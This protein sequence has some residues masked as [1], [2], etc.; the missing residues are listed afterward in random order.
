MKNIILV[1]F[2][3]CVFSLSAQVAEDYAPNRQR[4]T[5]L[6]FFKPVEEHLFSGDGMPYFHDGTFYL[7]WLLDEGHHSGLGGLG[8]H[9][10]ALS[11]S[12]DLINWKHYPVAL[13]INNEDWEKSICTGSVI[14]EKDEIYAFYATRVKEG[15]RVHE[16]LSYAI[17]KDGGITFEK[18]QPNPFYIAPEEC[19]SRDFRDPK[20]FKDEQGK[21]H[22]FISGYLKEESL[23]GYGG[24]LVH[25]IS[26]DLKNWVETDSPLKGQRATPECSDYFKWND[27][28]YLVYSVNGSTQYLKSK[29]PYGPWEYPDSQA[30]SEYWAVVYKTAAFKDNRRIAV[31][32]TPCRKDN[33]NAGERIWGGNIAFRELVQQKD[34]SLGICF[35]REV[36]PEMHPIEVPKVEVLSKD[37]VSSDKGI[38]E[39]NAMGALSIISLPNLPQNYKISIELEPNGNYDELGFFVRTKEYKGSGYKIGINPSNNSVSLNE[40]SINAVKDLTESCTVE[41]LVWGEFIDLCINGKRCLLNRMPEYDK[42]QDFLIFLKNG[43]MNIKNIE[44]FEITEKI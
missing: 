21:F 31:A 37:N 15:E 30:L 29:E 9:Q 38:I 23:P 5:N 27:W 32:Y 24:Y 6:Q 2:L 12:T 8:G 43:K 14:A 18:Q 22:L 28:Y 4:T 19:V 36:L 11:T 17:S 34:G 44:L 3:F 40:I 7:Y 33:K 16:Q 42:D 41:I 20:V 35:L 26:D 10:W 1:S 13:G 25:L 39:M